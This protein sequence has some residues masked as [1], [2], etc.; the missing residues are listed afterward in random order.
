MTTD[1]FPKRLMPDG[2]PEDL[3]LLFHRINNQLGVIL[4]NAELLEAKLSDDTHRAR[5]GHV[6]A[7]ALEAISAVRDLRSVVGGVPASTAVRPS[8]AS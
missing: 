6:V 1:T 4:A 8:S 7:G 5:A 2:A 3:S